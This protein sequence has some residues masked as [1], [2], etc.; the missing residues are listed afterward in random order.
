MARGLL[1]SEAPQ[2]ELDAVDAA[3]PRRR[4]IR[5]VDYEPRPHP[6]RL[7]RRVTEAVHEAAV[8]GERREVRRADEARDRQELG[9]RRRVEPTLR[10][11]AEDELPRDERAREPLS[12]RA[13]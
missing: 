4:P 8:A 7:R 2:L 5:R 3:L 9:A 11:E 10:F 13:R 6:P 1:R 12:E